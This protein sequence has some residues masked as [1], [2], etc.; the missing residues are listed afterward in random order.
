M[1]GG[2]SS[3]GFPLQSEPPHVGSY[4]SW[5]YF[6]SELD[7]DTGAGVWIFGLVFVIDHERMGLFFVGQHGLVPHF[8]GV[9][10]DGLGI[11]L[12]DEADRQAVIERVFDALV[13]QAGLG[14]H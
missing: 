13:R 3:R 4:N 2:S 5:K 1:S 8:A 10:A 7:A 9:G 6:I 11:V 12:D 14:R